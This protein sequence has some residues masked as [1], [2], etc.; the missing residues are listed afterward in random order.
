MT[1]LNDHQFEYYLA[2]RKFLDNGDGTYSEQVLVR[3]L[4]NTDKWDTHD[5]DAA[6]EGITYVLKTKDDGTWRVVRIVDFGTNQT[7]LRFAGNTNN[8]SVLTAG[9]AWV[10]RTS[11]VYGYK[12]E[13]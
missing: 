9:G 7:T 13:A 2:K 3:N 1:S 8:P 12:E 4:E 11:L 10:V 6:V 5:V